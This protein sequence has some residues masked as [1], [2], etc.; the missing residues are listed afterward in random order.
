MVHMKGPISFCVRIDRNGSLI[1]RVSKKII[2]KT[3][4]NER[5]ESEE[6]EVNFILFVFK[7]MFIYLKNAIASVHIFRLGEQISAF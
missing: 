5:I 7:A 6:K 2:Y 4:S 1:D 3:I